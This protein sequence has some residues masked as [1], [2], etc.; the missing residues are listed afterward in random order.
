MKKPLQEKIYQEKRYGKK[1]LTTTSIFTLVLAALF[2]A[3][4]ITLIV[5]GAMNPNGA[6]QII[7]RVIVGVVLL[8]PAGILLNIG[9]TMLFVSRSMLDN[10]DGNVSDVGNSAMGTINITKCEKC[11]TKLS[12]NAKFCKSCGEKV[13][14]E[15]CETCGKPIQ[16]GAK[17]CEECGKGVKNKTK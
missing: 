15:K 13:E 17:F 6:W 3:G 2:L 16:K 1:E 4:G 14:Q 9:L 7:W 12:P 5:F 8:I 10:Q 11:G